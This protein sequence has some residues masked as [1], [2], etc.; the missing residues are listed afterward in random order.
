MKLFRMVV[1]HVYETLKDRLFFSFSFLILILNCE[2]RVDDGELFLNSFLT[3]SQFD[4]IHILIM[5]K[6]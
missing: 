4:F 6:K 5:Q 1:V 2:K 3:V